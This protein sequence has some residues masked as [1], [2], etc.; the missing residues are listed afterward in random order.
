MKKIIFASLILIGSFT[1]RSQKSVS[2]DPALG[3]ITMTTISGQPLD[4]DKL[5]LDQPFKLTL[6]ISNYTNARMLPAGSVKV[7][8]GFGSKLA[9]DPGFSLIAAEMHEYFNWTVSNEGGQLQ[10]T[11]D[12]VNPLPAGLTEV[13]VTL[14]VKGTVLGKSTVT[15]NFLVSNHRTGITLSD[16]DPTNNSTFLAYTVTGKTAVSVTK[17]T[18]AARA[19]C[20]INVAFT[21]DKEANLSR[22]DVEVSK[23]GFNYTKVAEVPATGMGAYSTSFD[24]TDA[25]KATDLFVRVRSVDVD[26]NYLFSGA[27]AVSGSCDK[28]V[29]PWVLNIYPNPAT[30]VKVVS[31][32]AKQGNFNGKYKVTLLDM[33]GR[34]AQVTELE[35]SNTKTISYN[36]GTLGA[37]KYLVQ[38][39]NSDG[40]QGAVLQF[41]KL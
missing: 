1:A 18:T 33:S 34:L 30:D 37:G 22:Y 24:L 7:K 13:G 11:G 16:S 25:I 17:I 9:I 8:L 2:S 14:K 19:A 35:L 6:P 15:A 4:A 27:K 12:L 40:S 23:D 36:L 32:T 3:R 10:L 21:T 28:D 26:G 41:E 39:V 5:P 38:V 29:S 20:K 31:I